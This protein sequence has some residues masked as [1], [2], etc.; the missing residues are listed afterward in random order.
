M[1]KKTKGGLVTTVTSNRV[2]KIIEARSGITRNL[3]S[4]EILAITNF[5]EMD[6]L[7]LSPPSTDYK[8][9]NAQVKREIIGNAKFKLK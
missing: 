1:K 7:L 2:C 3:T 5:E 6:V 4:S 8:H 9:R